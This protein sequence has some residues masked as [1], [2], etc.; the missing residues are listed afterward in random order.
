MKGRSAMRGK[1]LDSDCK[2]AHTSTHEYGL[3]D[4]R[5]FCYGLI[6]LMN[7]EALPKCRECGAFAFN[8][9]PMEED[10]KAARKISRNEKNR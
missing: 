8:A 5:V 4:T 7:D 10:E 1:P 3:D 2:K 6:D 9:K